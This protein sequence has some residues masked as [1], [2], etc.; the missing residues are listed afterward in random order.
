M[1]LNG[2]DLYILANGVIIAGAKSCD[3][4]VDCE[5]IPVSSPNDGAWKHSIA[6]RKSWAVTTNHLVMVKQKPSTMVE[7][8]ARA[9]DGVGLTQQSYSIVN[10]HRYS[11]GTRGLQLLVLQFNS[12]SN[13]WDVISN[14]TYDTYG[15][16]TQLA[17]MATAVGALTAGQLV[18]IT[19]FDACA[20]N[21]T[22]ATAIS[23][24]FNI[25][26]AMIPTF[27]AGRVA[28]ACIG[29]AGNAGIVRTDAETGGIACVKLALAE[30]HL[31]MTS[32][33]VK[34]VL[35]KVG[36]EV[37]LQLQCDELASDRLTGKAICKTGKV[38]ATIGNLLQGGW[39]WEGDGELT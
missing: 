9:H 35:T 13:Q 26:S 16:S 17:V 33:P 22:L 34:D 7:A 20:I 1:A 5:T 25:P 6:G 32:T 11:G 24:K 10:G 23:T 30:G 28:F 12:S 27:A 8:V 19:S 31:P 37:T 36:T 2:R 15:D 21:T 39:T 29:V 4:T 14:T 18:I 3:V 38:N